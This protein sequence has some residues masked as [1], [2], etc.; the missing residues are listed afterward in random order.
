MRLIDSIRQIF[1]RAEPVGTE[2]IFSSL[3]GTVGVSEAMNVPAFAACVNWICDRAASL[4]VKLYRERDGKTEE[5]EG[6]VRVRYLN[7]ATPGDTMTA[8]EM[9]SAM[10][11]DYLLYG[12]GFA[13]IERSRN[14]VV[15]LRYVKSDDVTYYVSADPLRRAVVYYIGGREVSEYSLLRI[16]RHTRDG[17]DGVS[18]IRE[19][20]EIVASAYSMLTYERKLLR[21]GGCR[22]TIFQSDKVLSDKA[23]ADYKESIRRWYESDGDAFVAIN[24]GTTLKELSAS[25]VELQFS[26]NK[27]SNNEAIYKLF[28]LSAAVLMGS[29][30]DEEISHAVQNAVLP[31]IA[32][33]EATLNRTLLL[34][35][36]KHD[37]YFAF[38]QKELLRGDIEK[39]YRAYQ[40]A[41]QSNFMQLDEVRYAEDLPPL[42]FNFLKLG[43][44]DVLF[45][46]DTKTVYTPNTNATVSLDS[47]EAGGGQQEQPESPPDENRADWLRANDRYIQGKDGKMSGSKPKDGADGVDNGGNSGIIKSS[48]KSRLSLQFFS[49][50]DLQNQKSRSLEQGISNF[51]K[52][53]AEHEEYIQNPKTHC[54]DWDNFSDMKKAGLIR[55]WNKEISNFKESIDNRINELKKRGDYNE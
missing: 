8:R 28:G 33:F 13:Y 9:R 19:S 22:K 6:D 39:R 16:L 1:R 42:G 11:R 4:P 50:K 43:L 44:N 30:T 31:I 24:S 17:A 38:D 49:E 46:P 32:D 51:K 3:S 27:T 37:H 18:V 36:E 5:V 34:E 12:Q 21:T 40:I 54:P 45:D 52:R 35:N 47:L 53:I 10:I 29:A 14:Q 26:Q 41:L 55:H 23:F 2:A 7:D 15:G 20:P 25:P 48:S